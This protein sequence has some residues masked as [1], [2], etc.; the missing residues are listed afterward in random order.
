MDMKRKTSI[1]K[2]SDNIV[3]LN[4]RLI[5]YHLHSGRVENAFN[6]EE[7]LSDDEYYE[8]VIKE[9]YECYEKEFETPDNR[10]EVFYVP[11]SKSFIEFYQL[12]WSNES[13]QQDSIPLLY[14]RDLNNNVE[15][16]YEFSLEAEISGLRTKFIRSLTNDRLIYIEKPYNNE[17][18][19]KKMTAI[20]GEPQ[21]PCD[22]EHDKDEST[23]YYIV[24]TKKLDKII[25]IKRFRDTSTFGNPDGE[26]FTGEVEEI[27]LD[28]HHFDENIYEI[29]RAHGMVE[30][31]DSFLMRLEK[32]IKGK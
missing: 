13:S 27:I 17:E 23:Y 15:A 31:K 12:D 10:K 2:T 3:I 11:V 16:F 32:Y 28:L 21:I 24:P 25:G 4:R 1:K 30:I 20:L 8:N 7:L 22:M 29:F 18:L 6:I 5:S 19:E 9:G 14:N 26:K